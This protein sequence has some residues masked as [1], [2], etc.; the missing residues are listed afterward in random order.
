M[1]QSSFRQRIAPFVPFTLTYEEEG[2]GTREISFKISFDLNAMALVEETTGLSMITDLGKVFE[3]PTISNVTAMFW[4]G[5]QKY[6]SD[7]AGV[8][9]LK[10][11]RSLL[12]YSNVRP[13]FR[14]CIEAFILQLPK[15]KREQYQKALDS[16]A[17]ASGVQN[18][19][20][21]QP[22]PNNA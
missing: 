18:E 15:E 5:I 22:G 20:P 17:S 7:Y 8:E 19:N 2:G 14:K 4:A 16:E 3:E 13:I 1:T 10:A 12:D 21:T 11:I 6:N 9:G